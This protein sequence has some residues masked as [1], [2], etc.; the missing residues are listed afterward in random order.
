M[1]LYK[2]VNSNKIK[3]LENKGYIT[4]GKET[5]FGECINQ[6]KRELGAN[7]FIQVSGNYLCG[8]YKCTKYVYTLSWMKK[9]PSLYKR[10]SSESLQTTMKILKN[11]QKQLLSRWGQ[12]Y[13]IDDLFNKSLRVYALEKEIFV[14]AKKNKKIK[15][16]K[17]MIIRI[18]RL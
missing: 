13:T 5:S 18:G 15:I 4:L 3:E 7:Y 9:H 1:N 10:M 12:S 16:L 8:K 6:H 11:H 14:K 2:I 17:S